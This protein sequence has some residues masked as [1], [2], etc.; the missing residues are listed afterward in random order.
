MPRFW[1]ATY[2]VSPSPAAN[3][4]PAAV[5]LASGS[6]NLA[7]EV[8]G[9]A[10]SSE[11]A[12]LFSTVDDLKQPQALTCLIGFTNAAKACSIWRDRGFPL[13]DAKILRD[14]AGKISVFSPYF[15]D[16]PPMQYESLLFAMTGI[17]FEPQGG[18][19]EALE[20]RYEQ[21]L[22]AP[23]GA[24]PDTLITRRA[25][26][27][28]PER[29]DTHRLKSLDLKVEVARTRCPS[30]APL[31][32]GSLTPVSAWS[33]YAR[34]PQ[35]QKEKNR[36]AILGRVS[37]ADIFGAPAFRFEDVEVLGFRVDLGAYGR[38][39]ARDLDRLIKPLNFHLDD[40]AGAGAIWDFCYR[41]A[42]RTL[43]I[44]LL[45]YG[46]MKLKSPSPP[47][48]QED[49]QSQHELVVRLLVGRVDDDTAQAHAP[50]VYVPA[51]F[52][53]NP[54][55]KV[56]GRDMQGFDKRM[57]NFCVL[58][59]G[60]HARLRPDGCVAEDPGPG[61]VAPGAGRRRPRPLGDISLISL[62]DETGSLK[63]RPILELDCSPLN[64]D[65]WGA[66]ERVD[67]GLAFG[68]FSLSG[69][70]W[71]QSD[72]DAAEF[73]RSFARSAVTESLQGF[74]SIQV[75]PVAD[76]GLDKAW[77]TGTFAVDDDLRI[78]RPSG[79]ASLTIH[80]AGPDPNLPSTPSASLYWN[81]L[82]EMLGDGS[83]AQISLPTG[84]WYRL[85]CSMD[86]TI[87]DGLDWTRPRP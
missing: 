75:S 53:D 6:R 17:T 14:G 15:G 65:D 32:T 28:S 61:G 31:V 60:K 50:A 2:L 63:G 73:R 87:D 27:W 47:M 81:L 49:Y 12:V 20:T 22:E 30:L 24:Q 79:V 52:V 5:L 18:A 25:T 85:L 38:D 64:Y 29:G 1:L 62:V 48:G 26:A 7:I 33:G 74:R 10:E 42:S 54:W 13:V 21:A 72:F 34:L 71:R 67:L 84:S 4:S 80:A 70:R 66:F 78:A 11:Y 51:I 56:L 40:T 9:D 55:S 68:S 59:D 16:D 39:F 44:E 36:G 45:R 58:Q 41:A 86:L 69:T 46:S 57:A 37:R 83:R 19:K 3:D 76:R 35:D 77:I 43:V 23:D 8:L 82:C